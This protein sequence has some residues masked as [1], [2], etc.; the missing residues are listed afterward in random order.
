ME[1]SNDIREPG[2]KPLIGITGPESTGK[3]QLAERL[4]TS[5]HGVQVPEYAR[6]YMEKLNRPYRYEDLVEIAD[7]QIRERNKWFRERKYWVFFDTDLIVTLVWF[8]QVYH[9][10][11]VNIETNILKNKLDFYLLCNPDIP[12]ID[13]PVRENG[14][15]KRELLFMKYRKELEHYGFDYAIV[16]GKGE[17]RFQSALEGLKQY[18]GPSYIKNELLN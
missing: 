13:D 2:R 17:A 9:K 3:S 8:E 14:G 6:V 5:F 1:K 12:W 18:F 11:P 4:G 7:C 10:C 16:S 15:E